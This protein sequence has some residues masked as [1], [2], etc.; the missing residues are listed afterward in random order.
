MSGDNGPAT[1]AVSLEDHL[2][3][4]LRPLVPLLPKPLAAELDSILTAAPPPNY[5]GADSIDTAPPPVKVVPYDLLAALSKWS[6]TPE[7]EQALA[8]HE[9]PLR[10]RD[11][12]MLA[13]LAGT[14]TSPDR[15]FPSVPVPGTTADS[16]AARRRELSDRRAVTAVLNALLTIGGSAIAAFYAS[17]RLAW[18][19]EWVSGR[20][21]SCGGSSR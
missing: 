18:K 4:T 9:P 12:T 21:S 3:D 11:Y 2:A 13:L 6:R 8:R 19:D 5:S 14:R 16:Q 17:G 7:G 10:A 20:T 15:R 1:L